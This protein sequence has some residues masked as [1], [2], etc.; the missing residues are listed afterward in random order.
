MVGAAGKLLFWHPEQ[1]QELIRQAQVL[2]GRLDYYEKELKQ[3]Y[4]RRYSLDRIIGQS[5]P[6]Q[7]AKRVAAQAA[8][9]ELAVLITGE[10]GTGKDLFAHAVHLMSHPPAKTPFV[11]GQLRGHPPASCSSPSCSAIDA[12][13]LYRSQPPRASRASFELA[14]GGT[15][16]LDEVGELPLAR[17]RSSCSG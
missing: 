7:S 1:L 8:A 12:R 9:S 2:E 10:T 6:M 11:T 5:K 15:I 17:C 14:N 4:G 3:L 13:G 16:F